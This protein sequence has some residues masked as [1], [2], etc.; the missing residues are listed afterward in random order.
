MIKAGFLFSKSDRNNCNKLY[1]RGLKPKMDVGR[2]TERK[3]RKALVVNNR[4]VRMDSKVFEWIDLSRR[5][6]EFASGKFEGE[7]GGKKTGQ[8]RQGDEGAG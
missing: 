5:I 6:V 8:W 2:G 1:F 4:G 7:G 3:V